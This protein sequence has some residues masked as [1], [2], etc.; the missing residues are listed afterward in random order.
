MTT[1]DA[2]FN[3]DSYPVLNGWIVRYN[4]ITIH[5]LADEAW[6]PYAVLYS[7]NRPIAVMRQKTNR[8]K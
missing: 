2:V 7:N 5:E 4:P 6:I 1:L 8:T 3:Y